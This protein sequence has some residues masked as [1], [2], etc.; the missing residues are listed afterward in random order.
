MPSDTN[1][2]NSLEQNKKLVER[3]IE[4]TWNQ[5]RFHLARNFVRR[6]FKYNLS[7]FSQTFEY[8][9]ASLVIQ[10]VRNSMDDFEVMLEDVVAEGDRIVTQSLFCGTLVKPLFGFIPSANVVTFSAVSF[11]EIK[12][13][14]IYSLN[15]LLDVGELMRQMNHENKSLELDL[16]ALKT[17]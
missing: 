2:D 13:G 15:T 17:G 6:D 11:W 1:I 14:Q 10:L 8:D 9:K 16:T 3:F 12:K 4:F 5:G 7:L